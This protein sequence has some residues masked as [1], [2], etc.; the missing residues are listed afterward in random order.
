M[1]RGGEVHLAVGGKQKDR[2]D[3]Y[4]IGVGRGGKW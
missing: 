2:G 1:V 3:G 4:R